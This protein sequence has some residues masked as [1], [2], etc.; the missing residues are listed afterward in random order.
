M[1]ISS[2]MDTSH[3]GSFTFHCPQSN[4]TLTGTINQSGRSDMRH[5]LMEAALE[6]ARL[7]S[8]EDGDS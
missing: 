5:A 4:L 1:T 2:F 3:W 8:A 6:F 7:D